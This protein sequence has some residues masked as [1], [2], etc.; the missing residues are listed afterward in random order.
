[1][2]IASIKLSIF[3]LLSFILFYSLSFAQESWELKKKQPDLLI[4]TSPYPGSDFKS[5]KAVQNLKGGMKEVSAILLDVEHYTDLFP[6]ALEGKMIQKFSDGHFIHYLAT[7]VPW[8]VDDRSG[9]YEITTDFNREINE[10]T[11]NVKCIPYKYNETLKTV[12][13]SSGNGYWK[14]RQLSAG[15]TEVTFQYHA[16][17]AGSIPAWLANSFV[18][19]HPYKTMQNLKRILASGKYKSAEVDFLK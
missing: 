17:P 2:K 13:M 10:I 7:D 18:V 5:F 1:M 6:D 8:P 9:I 3:Q 15:N 11:I 19:D 16:E 12:R 14:I 4:Y